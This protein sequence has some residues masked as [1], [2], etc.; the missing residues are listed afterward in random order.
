[1]A[2]SLSTA[3]PASWRTPEYKADWGLEA[4]HAA[5]A[6]AAGYTGLG[7]TVGVVDSGVYSAHPEFA[8]GRVKPL[9]ITGT[10]GSDGFYFMDGSGKPQNQSPQPSFF[11]AGD[12]YTAPGTYSPIYNDPHG[13]HV[14][15]T[16]GA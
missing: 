3:D 5:N 15:G 4:M 8:D 11:K 7:V 14:T 12:S 2:Q 10:F 9:T 1:M 16:I 6:Y 13:T